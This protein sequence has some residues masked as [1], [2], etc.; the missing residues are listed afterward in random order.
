METVNIV[1]LKR[2]LRL[3]D[4][5]PLKSALLSGK[6]TVLLY[7]FEP[8]LLGDNHYSERHWRF[9]WQSLQDMNRNLSNTG[10]S[11]SIVHGDAIQCFQHIAQK[12]HIETVYSHQEIGFNITFMRDQV[13]GAWFKHQGINWIETPYGAV[14][15]GA[16]NRDNWDN[17][18]KAVM[19]AQIE[20]SNIDKDSS[21][22]QYSGGNDIQFYPPLSWECEDPNFQYGGS[23]AAWTLLDSFFTD[24]GKDYY[25]SLS[26]PSS[27]QYACSRLSPYLAWG[28]ISLRE[29]Y[30]TLLGHW[31]QK[32]WRRSLVAF[33]SR[34]HWH[35]YFIQQFESES[36]IE[37]RCFNRAYERLI[38]QSPNNLIWLDA[39]KRGET[40]L[41]MVDACMRCVI[42]TGYLNFRMRSMLVSVLTHNL[43]CDWR[44]GV[45]HLAQQFLDFEPGIHF[46]QFQM[47]AGVTGINTIRIYNPTKQAQ[48][49]DPDGE[50]IR[51]WVPELKQV[52][53]PL[54]FEPWQLTPMEA[55]MYD[56]PE[57]SPY[58]NPIIDLKAQAQLARTRLWTWRGRGDVKLEGKRILAKH[59]RSSH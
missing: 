35:C 14:I 6:K 48:E 12:Y 58:L 7:I 31:H 39:W 54:L 51:K 17:N 45:K 15:R 32:G 38:E 59:V 46:A 33:S 36:E 11:L 43:H 52:P 10:H 16:K 47:Q 44:F 24:R 53:T 30:Q 28:N 55:L 3:S 18:W 37:T 22:I 21:I 13:L 34:L 26:N 49:Q 25:R 56:L 23:H 41:P 8:M 27:A 1:W 5:L 50:F 9:V 42:K 4:H 40:G 57:D 2:D 29:V 20:N 19:R